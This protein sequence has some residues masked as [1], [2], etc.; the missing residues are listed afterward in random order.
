MLRGSEVGLFISLTL[1]LKPQV[2][3]LSLRSIVSVR[4]VFSMWQFC[5]L[6]PPLSPSSGQSSPSLVSAYCSIASWLPPS[7]QKASILHS[8]QLLSVNMP[9]VSCWD[10]K[11]F[12]E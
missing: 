1:S 8:L 2:S 10:P 3:Y 7:L 6:L 12:K 4:W 5:Q 9:S 11:G